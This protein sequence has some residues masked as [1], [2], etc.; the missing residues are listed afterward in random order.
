M[1]EFRGKNKQEKLDII[2]YIKCDSIF[3]ELKRKQKDSV[4]LEV[5]R[6]FTSGKDGEIMSRMG[7][8]GIMAC[9]RALFFNFGVITMCFQFAIGHPA[10]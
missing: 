10:I 7:N 1:D 2:E 4:I 9:Y 3:I 8:R 5:R 6:A